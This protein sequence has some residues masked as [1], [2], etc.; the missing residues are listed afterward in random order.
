MKD[1]IAILDF[2][3]QYTQLIA[4]RIRELGVYA[5]IYP[6]TQTDFSPGVKGIILSGSP[7][8]VID[9]H[10]PKPSAEL[11]ADARPILGICYGL[12]LLNHLGG[13]RVEPGA[14][15]EYGPARLDVVADSALLQDMPLQPAVW[16]SHGDHV[17]LAAPG[18]E[19]VARSQ[20]GLIAAVENP[21][22][23][24]YG[25][26][27]HPE[28]SHTPEGKTLLH[29]F[30]HA[31]CGAQANWQM[32]DVLAQAEDEIRRTVGDHPV[33]VLVSGG[34]DS[35]VTAALLAKALPAEQIYALHV[36]SGLMRRGESDAV[37]HALK[38]L[39]LK[40]LN[41]V[42]AQEA[43]LVALSGVSDPEAKRHLIGDL[44]IEWQER[45]LK[46]WDLPGDAFLAQGTLYTD[47]I[48][49][50][51]GVGQHAVTIKTHHNV[52]S[53][54]VMAKREQGRILEPNR[55]LFKDEVRQLGRLLGLSPDLVDRHPFPGPGLAIRILGE[56]T[57]ERLEMLRSADEI[58]I[59]EIRRQGLY[60][61]IWQA[62]AVLLPTRT[63]GVQGDA[64]A[65]QHVVA[66]RAVESIDGMTA[67]AYRFPWEALAGI[68]HRI[69]NEVPGI[70]R[71]VYDVTAKPPATIEW[72]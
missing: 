4:R 23:K 38:A 29:N 52:G 70:G 37:M 71:V 36:D 28:V 69:T 55:F 32:V 14:T 31:I 53:P 30:V 64:R 34:V 33:L 51:H 44:F 39:G 2:G 61:A 20:D 7:H 8:S 68:A 15:R 27:F 25:V 41:L 57:P 11:M 46:D 47:L 45:A 17:S 63:V 10:S 65:Y 48:E 72:E 62:F 43:F 9:P 1:E 42:N 66:I 58:L 19:V 3:S 12:Q 16:M 49:S 18:F 22:A 54:L 60:D 67:D 40:N 13:G 5:A 56:V 59:G 21:A 50:G 35:T 24:R 26:Q 6:P